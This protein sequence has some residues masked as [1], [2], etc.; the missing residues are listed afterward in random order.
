MNLI[1]ESPPSPVLPILTPL[2]TFRYFRDNPFSDLLLEDVVPQI[3]EPTLAGENPDI[4][5]DYIFCNNLNARN[6]ILINGAPFSVTFPL[7]APNG[8]AAA[9][10]YS[11]SANAAQG[12]Y[13]NPA[14]PY[15]GISK[16]SA[17][18][19]QIYSGFVNV[20][21]TL[22]AGSTTTAGILRVLGPDPNAAGYLPSLQF[23]IDRFLY[24]GNYGLFLTDPNVGSNSVIFGMKGGATNGY[25]RLAIFSSSDV[26]N[27]VYMMLTSS[28]EI[29]MRSIG[30]AGAPTTLG[31][32]LNNASIFSM[33][34]ASVAVGPGLPFTLASFAG[35]PASLLSG[36]GVPSA[37]NGTNGDFYFR[38]DT[39]ATANQRIY[40]KSAGA[41]VGIV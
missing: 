16:A 17:D 23:G 34:A 8:S 5:A 37:A 27:S 32:R 19:L 28:G 22:N 30:S 38:Y 41:W 29:A 2:Q 4:T 25:C 15:I 13:H 1:V 36:S 6:G 24:D 26:L 12:M 11:F 31:F 14:G 21:N 18:V 20:L 35:T 9:P 7:L 10:P 33:N 39:P 40:V 3:G